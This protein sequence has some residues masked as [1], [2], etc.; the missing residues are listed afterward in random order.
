MRS[1]LLILTSICFAG[2]LP[3][4]KAQTPM[5]MDGY[6]TL[7]RDTVLTGVVIKKCG[8]IGKRSDALHGRIMDVITFRT[9]PSHDSLYI[10]ASQKK[11]KFKA[12]DTLTLTVG[13]WLFYFP[14]NNCHPN[15]N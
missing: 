11:Q 7:R 4:L 9:V 2:F 6:R 13:P 8:G 3:S 10:V 14:N 15:K 5:S 12:G 1:L